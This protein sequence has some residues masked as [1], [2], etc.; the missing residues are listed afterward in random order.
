M[1][2][3]IN[4]ILCQRNNWLSKVY[5]FDIGKKLI[6]KYAK[7]TTHTEDILAYFYRYLTVKNIHHI[8]NYNGMYEYYGLEVPYSEWIQ[9]CLKKYI[10]V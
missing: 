8:K 9:Y 10:L 2:R 6:I 7:P 3:Y 1:E 4:F 5:L